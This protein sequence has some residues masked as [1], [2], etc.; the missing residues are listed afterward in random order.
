[1]QVP[2]IE[3]GSW[4]P[5]T[6]EVLTFPYQ[7]SGISGKLLITLDEDR[8]KWDY[9]LYT[10]PST[11]ETELAEQI[12]LTCDQII[13][14][15][16]GSYDN[17]PNTDSLQENS[18]NHP[19]SADILLEYRDRDLKFLAIAHH[20]VVEFLGK[21]VNYINFDLGQYWVSLG[22]AS[23]WGMWYFFRETDAKW[24]MND[25]NYS[26]SFVIGGLIPIFDAESEEPIPPTFYYQ[27]KGLEKAYWANMQ[28]VL[29]ET[30]QIDL[31]RNLILNAKRHLANSDYRMAAVESI[32]ALVEC[33][34]SN[35]T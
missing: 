21:F 27:S 35:S 24:A 3:L 15:I 4:I 16:E 22:K 14:R 2:P 20:L 10:D 25:D 8:V 32:A 13:V 1:M 5:N 18:A 17:K 31:A 34:I 19:T 12:P 28:E 11:G 6:E 33:S 29:Q 30:R 9:I 26:G 7:R 23:E